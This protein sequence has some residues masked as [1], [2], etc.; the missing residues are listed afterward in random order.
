VGIERG[1]RGD[2]IGDSTPAEMQVFVGVVNLRSESTR[3]ANE[4]ETTL[5]YAIVDQLAGSRPANSRHRVKQLRMIS[6]QL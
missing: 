1:I 4:T 6:R 2:Q 3:K 5:D